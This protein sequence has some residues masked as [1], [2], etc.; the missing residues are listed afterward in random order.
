[1]DDTDEFLDE[2]NEEKCHRK[3]SSMNQHHHSLIKNRS[4]GGGLG[5][6]LVS[7]A[8]GKVNRTSLNSY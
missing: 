4:V 7:G 8:A 2:L 1:M 6:V 3:V 5:S